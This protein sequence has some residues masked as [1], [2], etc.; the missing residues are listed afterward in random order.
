M[1]HRLM[2]SSLSLPCRGGTVKCYLTENDTGC[3]PTDRG[4][5]NNWAGLIRE[6][7]VAGCKPD[8]LSLIVLTHVESD[9]TLRP[10]VWPAVL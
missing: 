1:L 3:A 2:I 6:L 7:E 4:A 5:S 10:A 8:E 9:D